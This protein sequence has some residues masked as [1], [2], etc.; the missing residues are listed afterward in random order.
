MS[1]QTLLTV[2]AAALS[3]AAIV[4]SAIADSLDDILEKGV[5]RIAVPQD[6]PPYGSP[7]KD[8]QVEGYDV[9]VARLLAKDLGAK[10]QLVP[11]TS[12]NRVPYLQVG[13]VDLV[14]ATLG[15]SPE[16]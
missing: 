8:G 16:R 4:P 11:V 1:F 12:V 5:V 10:L 15:V 13:K 9:D 6:F 14:V 7:G 3:L 2:L